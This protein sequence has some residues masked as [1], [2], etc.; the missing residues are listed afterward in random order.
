MKGITEV[1]REVVC[2]DRTIPPACEVDAGSTV[3]FLPSGEILRRLAEGASPESIDLVRANAVTGPV[4]VRGAEPGDALRIEILDIAIDRAWTVWMEG[5]G[6]LGTLTEGIQVFDAPIADGRVLIGERL[7]VAL[8]PMI[9]CVGVAPADGAASTMR[10]VYPTGG[11]MDLR[12]LSPGA[13]LWLPV[14]APGALLSIGD[15]HAAMGHGEPAFVALEAA[16]TATVRVDL[17]R[18]TDLTLPRIRS[19][20]E[21]ACIGMGVSYPEARASAVRQAF[22]LLTATHGLT[23]SEAHAY[24]CA[25]VELRPAGPSGSIGDDLEAAVAAV[26][27]PDIG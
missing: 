10:P 5:L 14:A 21:T 12:E 4:E 16:G 3:S 2:F 17:E 15:L 18:D 1:D 23:A 13:V 8:A 27:D 22:E 19:G 6:P 25:A 20:N 26:P 24:V 7:S 9:G 11:N